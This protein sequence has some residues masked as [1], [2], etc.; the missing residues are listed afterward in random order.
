MNVPYD[1]TLSELEQLIKEF[2]PLDKIVVPRD[3]MG[4]P[5]G[6]AFAYL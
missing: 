4:L 5:K 3:T 6:Y 1:A 2:A